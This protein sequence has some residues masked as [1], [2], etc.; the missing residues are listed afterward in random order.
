VRHSIVGGH[1]RI[2]S[3]SGTF[4]VTDHSVVEGT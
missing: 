2:A 1:A 3:S 4:L